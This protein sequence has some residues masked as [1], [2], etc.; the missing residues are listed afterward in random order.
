MK[1]E[2]NLSV[3]KS[4]NFEGIFKTFYS[5]LC[6]YALKFLRAE[7]AA[8]DLVQNLFIQ[9]WGNNKLNEVKNTEYFL[10]K[11]VKFKC[12]DFI[13]SK[14]VSKEISFESIPDEAEE[15]HEIS[16]DEIEPLMHYFASKLP[17]KTRQVFLLS[18]SEGKTY[19]E[20]ASEMD[21]SIKTVENQMGRA[22]RQMRQILKEHNFIS[23][24]PLL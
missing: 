19:K 17:P 2:V 8:E 15:K 3:S 11:C 4:I 10:L 18:R 20:I 12:I 21:I 14:N 22:L 5:P 9:L 16:E 24:I 1:K 23:L 13:R 7:D 6:N